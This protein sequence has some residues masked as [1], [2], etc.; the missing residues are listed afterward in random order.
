MACLNG[1][2]EMAVA[3]A[4]SGLALQ[5][6][7]LFKSGKTPPKGGLLILKSHAATARCRFTQ[8][9]DGEW[10]I[11]VPLRTDAVGP[12]IP[13]EKIVGET[14]PHADKIRFEATVKLVDR[15]KGVYALTDAKVL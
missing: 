6:G 4:S 5:L 14:A 11:T 12:M 9:Q 13:G 3:I 15:E 8:K 10:R 1:F 2:L 7:D